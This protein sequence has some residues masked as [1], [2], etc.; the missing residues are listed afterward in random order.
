MRA[1]RILVAA[2]VLLVF[3]SA[4]AALAVPGRTARGATVRRASASGI[5]R[6]SNSPV[7]ASQDACNGNV[8]AGFVPYPPGS[9]APLSSSGCN[10]RV[11]IYLNGSG[12]K[13]NWWETTATMYTSDGTICDPTA[14]FWAKGPNATQY[15]IVDT[16]TIYECHYSNGYWYAYFE[17]GGSSSW[18]NNT[19]LGNSWDPNPPFSG[20]PTE[21][22]H[23]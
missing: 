19:R 8:C 1:I 20:F 2:T 5:E 17:S 4:T 23:S 18:Q 12:L 7:T 15:Y 6:T 21:L 13:V 11:C 10:G 16:V 22:V 14:Y 3:G 9:V